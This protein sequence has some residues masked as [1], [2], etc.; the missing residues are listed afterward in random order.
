LFDPTIFDNLK[1]SLEGA[2]YDLDREGALSVIGRED[3]VDLAS[4]GRTFR[5]RF[6]RPEGVCAGEVTLRSELDDFAGELRTLRIADAASAP[7]AHL[8]LMFELPE[9]K[10][11]VVSAA[12]AAI[13]D[14][15]SEAAEI[16]L[17]LATIIIPDVREGGERRT[18]EPA[19]KFGIAQ[20]SLSERQF[21]K[22]VLSFR[23]KIDEA[24]IE[25]IPMMLEQAV[26]SLEQID[27][28]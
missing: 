21:A 10:L 2:L 6:R 23:G 9:S 18:D 3:L 13:A 11:E 14:D 12:H 15:W 7:G 5:M 25:E 27:A 19:G 28:I 16:A 24:D 8:Q 4:M 26:I 17:E 1:V 20:G 22:I